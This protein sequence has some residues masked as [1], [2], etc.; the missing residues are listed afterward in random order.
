MVV[1]SR[2]VRPFPVW[3]VGSAPAASSSCTQS[4]QPSDA[5]GAPAAVS[6]T[7]SSARPHLAAQCKAVCVFSSTA[8]S[9]APSLSAFISASWSPI[10]AAPSKSL[11][12]V[13]LAAAP[14]VVGAAGAAGA[15]DAAVGWLKAGAAAGE[16]AAAGDGAAVRAGNGSVVRINAYLPASLLAFLCIAVHATMLLCD[17]RH[18]RT[19]DGG[20]CSSPAT[21]RVPG[22]SRTGLRTSRHARTWG[23]WE[24]P[25]RLASSTSAI[26]GLRR[27]CVSQDSTPR[28]N[29]SCRPPPCAILATRGKRSEFSGRAPSFRS[30]VPGCNTTRIRAVC[31]HRGRAPRRKGTGRLRARPARNARSAATRNWPLRQ[32][33]R[34]SAEPSAAPPEIHLRYPPFAAAQSG[35]R[36]ISHCRRDSSTRCTRH[37]CRAPS[38][39]TQQRERFQSREVLPHP[40]RRD[41]HQ[42][43]STASHTHKG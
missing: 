37:P 31:P 18:Q 12:A 27:P 28:R 42:P 40:T 34:H 8:S 35:N 10:S 6:A 39:G 20:N 33:G 2:A 43:D 32:V 4:S 14:D 36:K 1:A 16:S 19:G 26:A 15:L 5:A 30:L 25:L 17:V 22:P 13:A 21:S 11:S 23:C 3:S 38:A 7:V 24:A 29:L 41:A 9:C